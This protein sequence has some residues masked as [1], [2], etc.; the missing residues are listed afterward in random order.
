MRLINIFLMIHFLRKG[1]RPP[2]KLKSLQ[3]KYT[4]SDENLVALHKAIL[5]SKIIQKIQMSPLTN[6]DEG[7]Y[8]SLKSNI[9]ELI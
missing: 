1:Y 9:V 4:F 6:N 3:H 7:F 2:W 5:A 8:K